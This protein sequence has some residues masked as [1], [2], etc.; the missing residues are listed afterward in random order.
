MIITQNDQHTPQQLQ[1]E[2]KKKLGFLQRI[3]ILFLLQPQR[4]SQNREQMVETKGGD[5]EGEGF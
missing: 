5:P 3:Y 1:V 2:V 4:A